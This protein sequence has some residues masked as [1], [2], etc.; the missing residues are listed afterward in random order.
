[1]SISQL[2]EKI[3]LAPPSGQEEVKKGAGGSSGAIGVSSRPG[4]KQ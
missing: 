3:T 4:R 2:S 1:M